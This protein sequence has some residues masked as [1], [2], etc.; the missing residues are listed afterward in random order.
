MKMME[1]LNREREEEMKK[2]EK[3]KERMKM[4][5][6]LN[7]ERE[8]EMKKHEKEKER[9]S[10]ALKTLLVLHLTTL[11]INFSIFLQYYTLFQCTKNQFNY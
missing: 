10:N 7:R 6:K 8:E 3:E 2:H 5:E 9:I 11:K 4:M 1:K